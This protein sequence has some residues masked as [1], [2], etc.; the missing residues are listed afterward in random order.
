MSL[1]KKRRLNISSKQRRVRGIHQS[2]ISN[3]RSTHG[4]VVEQNAYAEMECFK[5]G[6]PMGRV[7]LLC[8][9]QGEA[10][11]NNFIIFVQTDGVGNVC[12]RDNLSSQG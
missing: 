1:Q 2:S 3:R 12:L 5:A 7:M 9:L 11:E 6:R 10:L 4:G 8:A